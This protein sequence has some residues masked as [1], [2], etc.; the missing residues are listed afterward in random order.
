MNTNKTGWCGEN[1]DD[2][3]CGDESEDDDWEEQSSNSLVAKSAFASSCKEIRSPNKKQRI[4]DFKNERDILVTKSDHRRTIVHID[5][6]CF[7]AQV[8][9]LR[10][11]SL[12]DKPLGI[13]QKY[14]LVTCN[15][16][17]RKYGV[18]K[19]MGIKDA[20][21]KCPQL[22]IVKGEDLTHY[23]EVSYKLTELLQQYT[24]LVERLGFDE[25]FLDITDIVD[26]KLLTKNSDEAFEVVGHVYGENQLT[27]GMQSPCDC[28]CIERLTIGT[29]IASDIRQAVYQ[30]IGLT[31]CAGVAHNKVL[32][33]LVAGANKPNDQT[34][35]LPH[36]ADHLLLSLSKIR[37]IPGIGH[38]TA[39][40]LVA[41]G[42]NSVHDLRVFPLEVL[43][44][45]FGT[46]LAVTMYQL[47]NGIDDSPVK[48][49]GAP[50]SI[51]DEDSFKK[52][53]KLEEAKEHMTGLLKNLITRIN[54]DGRVP[55]TI[56]VTV[57]K[58]SQTH[59]WSR[60]SRQC[61]VPN[62]IAN[63]F[64][65]GV[66]GQQTL[67]NKL[68]DLCVV[69]F[70]KMVDIKNQFHLTLINVCFA[71]LKERTKSSSTIS[72]FFGGTNKRKEV[73]TIS[74]VS[75]QTSNEKIQTVKLNLYS[76]DEDT[77]ALCHE[78]TTSTAHDKTESNDSKLTVCGWFEP[79]ITSGPESNLPSRYNIKADQKESEQNVFC[80]N[81]QSQQMPGFTPLKR[82][83]STER[84]SN[85]S[86]TVSHPKLTQDGSSGG[87]A[88][89]DGYSS[90][91]MDYFKKSKSFFAKKKDS[92]VSQWGKPTHTCEQNQV[93]SIS[94]GET[95][96]SQ[97]NG[98]T[99]PFLGSSQDIDPKEF[100][101][102][103]SCTA[104]S[105]VDL[106]K[107]ID[108]TVFAELPAD[109]QQEL[110]HSWKTDF[111]T[112]FQTTSQQ[113]KPSQPSKKQKTT[114]TIEQYFSRKSDTF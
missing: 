88:S 47:A 98:G 60:E 72:S 31:C 46:N 23:R 55:Q 99:L 24:P 86:H 13:Q 90:N 89:T 35:L 45:E 63:T 110:L 12:K 109:V 75:S 29:H 32:A 94:V 52:C 14:L 42:M 8:E 30:D 56:R 16:V 80:E 103:Q 22:V 114:V 64:L 50:Q 43:Q 25:N 28:G 26:R 66:T 37:L 82:S 93:T 113:R 69:L 102:L 97:M 39:K 100:A 15:Y 104:P 59:K 10:N 38:T 74:Q 92:L 78:G 101:E 21:E 70:C 81:T 107:G 58:F 67:L 57:R 4:I 51:S 44:N 87:Y 108:S 9:M 19:L 11:P 41:M 106:P 65:K 48:P 95:A 79:Q 68:L 76:A 73:S 77:A 6:D 85:S 53:S 61:S 54:N 2:G 105:K 18:T 96:S 27:S 5:V 17:A 20:L 111:H 1:N 71:K 33:K 91:K 83:R 34:L 7:Y 49:S 84:L 36:Q 3:L 112:P 40:R 62:D